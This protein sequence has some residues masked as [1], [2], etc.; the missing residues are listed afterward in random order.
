MEPLSSATGGL[1]VRFTGLLMRAAS[2][3][4]LAATLLLAGCAGSSEGSGGGSA[5]PAPAERPGTPAERLVPDFP[6][7]KFTVQLGAFQSEEGAAAAAALAKSRFSREVYAIFDGSDRLYKVMLGAFDTKEQARSFR[8]TIVR[9]F[10]E[11]YRDAW[12]SA[13]A[14]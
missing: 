4:A 6:P 8:D 2:L 13:L 10:P 11:E 3:G 7:G 1:P 9:Q 12:V 5:T 14:R